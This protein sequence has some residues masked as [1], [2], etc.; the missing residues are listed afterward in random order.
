MLANLL[1]TTLERA[2]ADEYH[3]SKCGNL[4][5]AELLEGVFSMQSSVPLNGICERH[6]HLDLIGYFVMLA[7]QPARIPFASSILQE[8]LFA[9]IE[10]E[11]E[12]T[13]GRIT[14]MLVGMAKGNMDA[15]EA[16]RYLGAQ[17]S[18]PVSLFFLHTG[19]P[20]LSAS[21]SM[22]KTAV[23]GSRGF[24]LLTFQLDFS[25]FLGR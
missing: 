11:F 8:K 16:E 9:G 20:L 10:G 17:S 7:L 6:F 1:F 22:R 25:C 5:K 2:Q 24:I 23:S 14:K 12:S 18:K 3:Y 15:G 13:A 21:P 19:N 4:Q